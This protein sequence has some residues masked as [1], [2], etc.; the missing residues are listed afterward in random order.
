M[1]SHAT[2]TALILPALQASIILSV[3][4]IGLNATIADATYLFRRPGQLL[5]AL[6]SMNVLM[7]VTAFIVAAPFDLHPAVKIALVVI[8]IS[9]TPPVLPKKAL[10]AGRAETY[11]IGLLTAAAALSIV[12]VPLTL[13]IIARLTGA[14]LAMPAGAVAWM[15]LTSILAPLL[16]GIAVRAAAH[17][18][19]ARIARPAEIFATVLLAVC[20]VPVVVGLAETSVPLWTDGTIVSLAG[21]ALAGLIIGHLLGG[22]DTG[23]RP[24]LALA[25]A[26]RHPAIAM[27]IAHA[28]FPQQRLA[29][30]A[31]L[32]YLVFASVLFALYRAWLKRRGQA[33]AHRQLHTAAR[34]DPN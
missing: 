8:S 21:F 33:P 32:L 25:T 3:F 11:T 15:V 7:P 26:S 10:K 12:I 18:V 4:A 34:F 22:P 13:A 27:A 20:A 23:N 2:V 29:G 19:A 30:A 6:V 16:A 24:V 9:P 1:D 14:S 5:R 28:N 17:A 31:V